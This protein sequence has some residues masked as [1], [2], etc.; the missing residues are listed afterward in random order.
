MFRVVNIPVTTNV[1]MS[2]YYTMIVFE[3]VDSH[4]ACRSLQSVLF[5]IKLKTDS[6]FAAATK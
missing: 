4:E 5:V 6:I 1:S 3:S 2:Q